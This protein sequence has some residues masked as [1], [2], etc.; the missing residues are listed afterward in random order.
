MTKL[1]G[2][3]V[4]FLS[5][6]QR[7]MKILLIWPMRPLPRA[8]SSLVTA[9]LKC[10]LLWSKCV[11]SRKLSLEY[12]SGIQSQDLLTSNLIILNP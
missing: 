3:K 10:K 5:Y 9:Y 11:T 1:N 12:Q 6:H 2:K 8:T 4:L 7:S